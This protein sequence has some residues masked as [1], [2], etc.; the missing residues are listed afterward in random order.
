MYMQNKCAQAQPAD[1]NFTLGNAL[2]VAKFFGKISDLA[3][4]MNVDK[5]ASA[6]NRIETT[7]QRNKACDLSTA[8]TNLEL[9]KAHLRRDTRL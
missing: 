7:S 8:T 9:L 2:K 5:T 1:K 6:H 3:T 4:V